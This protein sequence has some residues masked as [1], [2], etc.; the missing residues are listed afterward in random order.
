[1]GKW[2]K[3]VLDKESMLLGMS[4]RS[5][6]FLFIVGTCC[7]MAANQIDIKEPMYS[8]LTMAVGFYFGQKAGPKP[9]TPP[10]PQA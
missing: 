1:M 4:V 10:T 6:G 8:V 2:I 5:V 9:T 3:D 7:W